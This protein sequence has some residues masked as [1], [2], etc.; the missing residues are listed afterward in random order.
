MIDKRNALRTLIL[1]NLPVLLF[2]LIFIVFGLVTPRF[3]Q[4][5]NLIN[6]V[7]QASY[8]GVIAVGMTFVLL[9][10]G[11]D[12]SVGSNMYLSAAVAGALINQFDVSTSLACAACLGVG[13]LFGAVNAAIVTRLGVVPFVA[14]LSTM[15][16]GRGLGLMVTKSHVM[17]FPDR[18]TSLGAVTLW[19]I[20]FPILIFIAVVTAAWILLHRTTPGRQLYAVGHHP[21]NARKAGIHV[22]R[23]LAM[24]YILCGGFAALG[25]F[26][27]IIQL[28]NLNAGFGKGDEFDAISAAVLGGVSL[29]GG[30][31]SVFPGVVLGAVLIQMVSAGLVAAQVN[32][33]LHPLVA[34]AIIFIAVLLDSFR[35]RQLKKLSRRNLRVDT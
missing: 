10:A 2:M 8:I 26:I 23:R 6:A 34:A 18:M 11:I 12:L 1:Q 4:V 33:Y 27:S 16:A 29:F 32:L 20:P 14:T 24:A 3:L 25:G 9:T 22:Q 5:D 17:N 30:I 35:T 28:G 13:L 15:V 7:K 31:G 19:G 21:E